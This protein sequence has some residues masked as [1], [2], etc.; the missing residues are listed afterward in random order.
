MSFKSAA[1]KINQVLETTRPWTHET[2][3]VAPETVTTIKVGRGVVILELDDGSK[4]LFNN[5]VIGEPFYREVIDGKKYVQVRFLEGGSAKLYTYED[6]AGDLMVGDLVNVP[7]VY[8]DENIAKVVA[9]G[10]GDTV[11]PGMT[12]KRVNG[13]YTLQ[14]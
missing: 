11:R 2:F 1:D 4:L 13:R 6:T 8:L 5:N 14:T 9:L 10:K 12:M 3:D 7:A